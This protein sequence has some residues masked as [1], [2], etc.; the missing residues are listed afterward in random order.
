LRATPE[1]NH[2]IL[3]F[4]TAAYGFRAFLATASAP[5]AKTTQLLDTIK[6]MP[7]RPLPDFSSIWQK[8]DQTLVAIPTTKPAATKLDGMVR[9]EGGNYLFVVR[10]IEI[11]E[12][13]DIGVD[14]QYPWE[15]SPKLFHERLMQMKTL[16]MDKYPVTNAGFKKF[17]DATHYHRTDD[18]NLQVARTA[19]VVLLNV[20]RH[21]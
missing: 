3:S 21:V 19:I 7:A 4:N 18:L 10:G 6:A 5:D 17:L 15:D 13:N 9:I 14:V 2:V 20:R 11:E 12:S 16:Y 1:G 8:T